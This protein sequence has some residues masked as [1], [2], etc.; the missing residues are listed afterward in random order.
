MIDISDPDY[1][2]RYLYNVIF[3]DSAI[4]LPS[5]DITDVMALRGQFSITLL[6]EKISSIKV[7]LFKKAHCSGSYLPS[8]DSRRSNV[9]IT[10]KTGEMTAQVLPS[11]VLNKGGKPSSNQ[12]AG[13]NNPQRLS[14]PQRSNTTRTL[15]DYALPKYELKIEAK[16]ICGFM[17]NLKELDGRSFSYMKKRKILEPL[18]I[19]FISREMIQIETHKENFYKV[20][21]ENKL[22][23]EQA[24]LT[25][26][27]QD[28]MYFTKALIYNLKVM[29]S[30]FYQRTI[31][32]FKIKRSNFPHN[33]LNAES[34]QYFLPINT[35]GKP[36]RAVSHAP[37]ENSPKSNQSQSHEDIISLI[38]NGLMQEIEQVKIKAHEM[39]ELKAQVAEDVEESKSPGSVYAT[40]QKRFSNFFFEPFDVEE[41]FQTNTI[42]EFK[43]KPSI[44]R[45]GLIANRAKSIEVKKGE[46]K[47]QVDL[48]L[49]KIVS[50][51]F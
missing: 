14:V 49:I 37:Q 13:F 31:I 32:G 42:R 2:P 35:S 48:S 8:D 9:M 17:C 4:I 29:E 12:P 46:D 18:T 44:I 28:A 20:F 50:S 3:D 24:V 47:I 5:E 19:K 10:S 7:E 6:F 27:Y 25:V 38:K 30:E 43:T 16:D 21:W 22:L 40:P 33:F 34:A 23:A 26:T 11:L 39:E 41:G 45:T 1:K 36:K 51:I 15:I